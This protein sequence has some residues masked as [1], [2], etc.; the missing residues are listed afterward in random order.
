MAQ[1]L[2]GKVNM[3]AALQKSKGGFDPDPNVFSTRLVDDKFT[4]VGR[5]LPAPDVDT[6][7]V[8]TTYH[9]LVDAAGR[10]TTLS[11]P[12]NKAGERCPICSYVNALYREGRDKEAVA[13]L[14]K[15]NH[16]ANFLVLT[17]TTA[18]ETVGKVF[19]FRYG[20]DIHKKVAA[21]L[22]G[23]KDINKAPVN[24]FD[25]SEGANF[26]VKAVKK[27]DFPNYAQS[28]F[29]NPTPLSEAEMYRV[30]PLLMPL[31]P[32]VDKEVARIKPVADLLSIF[33]RATGIDITAYADGVAA[34]QQPENAQSE[35]T[36]A[37]DGSDL[38]DD[39]VAAEEVA[40]PAATPAPAAVVPP[41]A[42]AA[43]AA[44][45]KPVAAAAPK[46]AAKP[47]AGKGD[48]FWKEFDS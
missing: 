22:E 10:K 9:Q 18:P 41:K 13:Y 39:Q 19:I 36:E 26:I 45:A 5:F 30:D 20:V 25:Y 37:G 34:A 46:A 4:A 43:P 31:Q 48:D 6:G 47:A 27:G 23:D 14:A 35:G 12:R 1:P 44:A 16:Y 17:N 3:Q 29:E 7:Y 2:R 21:A 40:A 24:V 11:C 8:R 42:A 32:Y 28:Q 15:K 38:V 33:Y